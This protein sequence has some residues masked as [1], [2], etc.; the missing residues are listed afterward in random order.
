MQRLWSPWRM[1]YVTGA[2]RSGSPGK[3]EDIFIQALETA[4]D[5]DSLVIHLGLHAFIVMNLFP[6]NTGHMMVVPKRKVAALEDLEPDERAELMELM[7]LAMRAARSVLRC[8]GFNAGLNVG[9]VAG[10]GIADH[11]HLHIVPRWLGDA[12]FMPI[13]ASTMVMPELL[14]ATTARLKG[15]L[16]SMT[17]GAAADPPHLTAGAVVYLPDEGR[18][19]LRR[20][21]DGTIVVPKGHIEPGE[22]AADTAIREVMEETGYACTITNWAGED[23]FQIEGATFHN[24]YFFAVGRPTPE[25]EA[26][27]GRDVELAVPSE[28]AEMIQFPDLRRI[29]ER[30]VLLV[31]RESGQKG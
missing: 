20:A 6:Y 8:D 19:V 25:V 15:E 5:P 3:A 11:L 4:G 14:P 18:L 7:T 12:N 24:V 1:P 27:L 30:G 17:V 22:S 29:V 31:E 26:H 23:S 13:N 9:A 10:A 21:R 16:A 28:A 2:G